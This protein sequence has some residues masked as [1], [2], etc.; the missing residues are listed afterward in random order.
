MS[1][2]MRLQPGNNKNKTT[3]TIQ[4]PNYY[5]PFS[6][7]A[8]AY[9]DGDAPYTWTQLFLTMCYWGGCLMYFLLIWIIANYMNKQHGRNQLCDSPAP[10]LEVRETVSNSMLGWRSLD[11]CSAHSNCWM[12]ANLTTH[13]DGPAPQIEVNTT[14]FNR[15]LLW[16]GMLLMYVLLIRIAV[17]STPNTQFT[18]V[19]CLK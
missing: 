19:L 12:Q 13:R 6:Q 16:G 5:R 10:Q 14:V 18:L 4:T 11:V 9:T 8:F 7:S 15:M 1:V 2:C 17:W 3:T